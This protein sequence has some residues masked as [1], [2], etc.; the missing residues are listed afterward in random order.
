M[1]ES[2]LRKIADHCYLPANEILLDLLLKY[3]GKFRVTFSITGI[4]M[5]QF[6]LYAP[7]VLESFRRLAQTGYVEFL[8]E[9]DSHSLASLVNKERFA[10]QVTNHRNKIREYL[11]YE[12]LSI[13][14]TEL[15]Y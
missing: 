9:T 6:R 3:K 12:P 13:R 14:N 15:I 11:G 1:N 7:E 10:L 2:I 5:D 4:A 8:A